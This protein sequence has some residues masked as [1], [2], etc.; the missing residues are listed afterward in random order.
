MDQYRMAFPSVRKFD[1]KNYM[2]WAFNMTML[3]SQERCMG[4]FD[5]SEKPQ[6]TPTPTKEEFDEDG[7]PIHV[8]GTSS[9]RAYTEYTWR[10]W[11]A[12]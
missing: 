5:R 3:L 10:Y 1:G 12:L 7:K 4:I 6:P 8:A 2:N 11:G 9:A